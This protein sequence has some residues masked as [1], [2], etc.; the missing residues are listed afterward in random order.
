MKSRCLF[1][2]VL[3]LVMIVSCKDA[4][5][6]TISADSG[7]E[8]NILLFETSSLYSGD[9]VGNRDAS[10]AKCV[11]ANPSA[12]YST[13][14]AMISYSGDAIVDYNVTAKGKVVS[15]TDKIIA[16]S[17]SDLLS[18][19]LL[20]TLVDAGAANGEFWSGSNDDGSFSHLDTSCQNWTSGLAKDIGNVGAHNDLAQTAWLESY[21]T[22]CSS[23]FR[24]LCVAY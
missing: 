9:Q 2:L 18:K 14:K 12:G 11:A 5:D 22:N 7:K 1:V 20:Q 24:L 4:E 19:D 8:T 23:G 21:G 13:V 10:T 17:W 15:P 3:V 6:V 16:N